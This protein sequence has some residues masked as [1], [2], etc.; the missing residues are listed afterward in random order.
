MFNVLNLGAGV[1]S[2]TV[3]LMS[4]RG[5][6]PKLDIAIFSDTGWEPLAVYQH[7]EKLAAHAAEHGLPVKILKHRNI[8]QDA[9]IAQVRGKAA[10]G[11][12]WVS[13]PYHTLSP[14]GKMGM[15]R[16]QC[17]SEY[18]IAPIEKELRALLGL[19]HRQRWPKDLKIQQWFGISKDEPQRMRNP[20]RSCIQNYYPLC[21]VITHH[22]GRVE[23]VGDAMTRRDCVLKMRSWGWSAPRSACIGC[24]FHSDDEWRH[25]RDSSPEEF[26]EAC[27]FDDAI[28]SCGGMRGKLFLHR[29]CRPLREI[30]FDSAEDKG[31][32]NWIN[33]CLGMCGT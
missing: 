18:K 9:L 14:R 28:R 25:L 10:G 5:E 31:Q 11:Q 4:L 24:P 16:R 21:G 32:L 17:T 29:S 15:I 12:R 22:D 3:L 20:A 13:I 26:A 2:T 7:L 6:L 19:E 33:E 8:K 23:S 1:Q 30:D 27:D